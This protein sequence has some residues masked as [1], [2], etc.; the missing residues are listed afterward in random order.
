M[1]AP[2]L[3]V[4]ETTYTIDWI[5]FF[6]FTRLLAAWPSVRLITDELELYALMRVVAAGWLGRG[7]EIP[8]VRARNADVAVLANG[9]VVIATVHPRTGSL[10]YLALVPR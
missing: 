5:T 9:Y 1:T 7:D 4:T 10:A 8:W 6:T 2:P 3:V